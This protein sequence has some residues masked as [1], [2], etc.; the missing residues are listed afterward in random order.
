MAYSQ[1]GIINLGLSHIGQKA[2]Q[3]TTEAT[4]QAVAAMRVWEFVLKETLASKQWGFANVITALAEDANY[5]PL[6]Y[7][8]AYA[9]PALGVRVWLVYDEETVKKTIGERFRVAY[10]PTYNAKIIETDVY[11]AYCEYTYYITDVTKYD[12]H[13]VTAISHR[14]AAELAIPL[15]GDKELAKEQME[16]FNNR[17]SEAHRFSEHEH[18]EDNQAN[19]TSGIIDARG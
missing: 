2:I 6:D 14:L 4:V 5:S 13:F 18:N 11:Q 17:T 7:S 9:Y 19:Q 10:S 15:N 3:S 12:P 16:V 8:Y 1:V